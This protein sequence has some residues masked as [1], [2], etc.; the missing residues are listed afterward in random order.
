LIENIGN[1]PSV[2]ESVVL[3]GC[4]IFRQPFIRISAVFDESTI[5]ISETKRAFNSV[6]LFIIADELK[7]IEFVN[8]WWRSQL[9]SILNIDYFV[10]I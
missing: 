7:G 9:K 1:D 5:S 4:E 2:V 6:V 10:L 8:S 3:R